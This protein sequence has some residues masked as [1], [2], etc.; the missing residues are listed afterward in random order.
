MKAS[1]TFTSNLLLMAWTGSLAIALLATPAPAQ[2]CLVVGMDKGT[3]LCS[4]G[5]SAGVYVGPTRASVFF[6]GLRTRMELVRARREEAKRQGLLEQEVQQR[7]EQIPEYQQ[8][9]RGHWTVGGPVMLENDSTPVCYATF[10]RQDKV[11][12]LS[13]SALPGQQAALTL[14]DL[15]PQ[16]PIGKPQEFDRIRVTLEQSGAKPATVDAFNHKF[17]DYPAITFA[18]PTLDIAINALVDSQSMVVKAGRRTL[19]SLEYRDGLLAKQQML[20]CRS[21]LQ[22]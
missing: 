7:L 20:Q 12:Y 5:N 13:G 19:Y 8:Y 9:M 3:P 21:L 10:T 17:D 15:D 6:Q 2:A 22:G 16:S 18:V 11:L 4:S 1:Q 14:V